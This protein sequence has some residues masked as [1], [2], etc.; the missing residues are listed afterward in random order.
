ML[1]RTD[2]HMAVQHETI[3][4]RHYRVAGYKNDANRKALLLI[5]GQLLEVSK[6]SL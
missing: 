4:P 3:T 5:P 2:R 6:T 1:A